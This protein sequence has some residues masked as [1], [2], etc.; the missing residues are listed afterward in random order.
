MKKFVA[1]LFLLCALAPAYAQKTQ[2]GQAPRAKQGVDYPLM[3]HV[4]GIHLRTYYESPSWI[5]PN[6]LA[7]ERNQDVVYA[8]AVLNGEK[9]E[10]LGAWTWV[11]GSYQTPLSPGDFP[12][13]L[14]KDAPKRSAGPLG[15][16]YELLLPGRIVWRCVVTGISE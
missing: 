8:D 15:Q 3:V 11:P 2:F 6:F 10:L 12:A 1:V 7:Q 14:L 4:S 9:M 16:E 5:G 13:R